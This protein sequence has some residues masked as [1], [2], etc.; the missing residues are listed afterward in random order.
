ME[1]IHEEQQGWN[2]PPS[3]N[4]FS[5]VFISNPFAIRKA[6]SSPIFLFPAF[7]CTNNYNTNIIPSVTTSCP[8]LTI[9]DTYQMDNDHSVDS[10]ESHIQGQASSKMH[11][12]VSFL[13]FFWLLLLQFHTLSFIHSIMMTEMWDA[14]LILH[15]KHQTLGSNTWRTTRM[16]HTF[17]Q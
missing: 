12:S 3:S 7:Q 4:C 5:E 10:V 15:I 11:S 1:T 2:T 8:F 13:L 6:P 14:Q 16:R 17:K 9:T